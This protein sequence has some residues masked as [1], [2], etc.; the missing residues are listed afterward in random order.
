MNP[1]V[2]A[3]VRTALLELMQSE[4][5]GFYRDPARVES[6]LRERAPDH[7][8]EVAAL[9]TAIRAGVV[10]ELLGV[11]PGLFEVAV[12]HLSG[13]MVRMYD[14]D[15]DAA[16]WAVE[17]WAK[18]LG[19][20]P[21]PPPSVLVTDHGR[22]GRQSSPERAANGPWFAIPWPWVAAIGA[23]VVGVIALLVLLRL[24]VGL[25]RNDGGEAAPTPPPPSTT[26]TSV[27]SHVPVLG[28]P[29]G[30]S[31]GTG[32]VQITLLWAD[33]NDLDLHVIDP[34]GVV[35][36]SQTLAL[37]MGSPATLAARPSTAHSR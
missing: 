34:S 35:T 9:V 18:A 12:G 19:A 5:E 17:S 37:A 33:G 2:D 11:K 24:V 29:P 27:A 14:S 31:L 32:D 23:G 22:I 6:R 36:K 25:V 13:R 15:P 30:L 7:P 20:G 8:A 3:D 4:G 16:R 28:V 1:A 26:S 21:E 10:D